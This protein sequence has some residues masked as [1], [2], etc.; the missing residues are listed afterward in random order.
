[1]S[2]T[3]DVVLVIAAQPNRGVVGDAAR[4]KEY[5]EAPVRPNANGSIFPESLSDRAA[6][7]WEPL[8]VLAD[9]AGGDWPER[10][11]QAAEGLTARAQE[12]SP[13]ASLLLDIM[14]MFIREGSKR[15]FTRTM[16]EVLNMATDRPWAEMRKG[17]KITDVWLGRQLRPYGVRPRSV[18]IGEMTAKGYAEEDFDE[19]FRRYIPRSEALAFIREMTAEAGQA[20]NSKLQ[21]PEKSQTPGSKG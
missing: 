3:V 18:R 17:K 5:V 11:R 9:L 12:S 19:V 15:M 1:M 8:L 6:D 20:P 4:P 10:A 14:L 16:V 2:G 21:A 7:I 13:I